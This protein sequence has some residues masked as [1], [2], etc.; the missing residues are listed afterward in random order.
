MQV[1][2]C[3]WLL[4]RQSDIKYRRYCAGYFT[5]KEQRD[6]LLSFRKLIATYPQS[7]FPQKSYYRLCGILVLLFRDFKRSLEIPLDSSFGKT[8]VMKYLQRLFGKKTDIKAPVCNY[9]I[10]LSESFC[11]STAIASTALL[12]KRSEKSWLDSRYQRTPD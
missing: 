7:R 2:S 1:F 10:M 12:W 3:Y 4:E 5:L 9:F 6:N 8:A 11:S